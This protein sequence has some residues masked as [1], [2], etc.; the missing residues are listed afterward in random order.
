MKRLETPPGKL[1]VV[2]QNPGTELTGIVNTLCS[3]T[4]TVYK[5]RDE[6]AYCFNIPHKKKK[7][8][9]G[10]EKCLSHIF[11][12]RNFSAHTKSKLKNSCLFKHIYRN[13]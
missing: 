4:Q 8:K 1:K 13:N 7:I 3:F 9:G 2:L 12:F 5:K 10:V 6:K 11:C